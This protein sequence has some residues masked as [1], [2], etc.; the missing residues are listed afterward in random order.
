MKKILIVED[1][2]LL[3]MDLE[4]A[5]SEGGY[6]VVADVVSGSEAIEAA[7][8]LLPDLILM[9][10]HLDGKMDGI[11]AAGIIRKELHLPVIYLTAHSDDA[12]LERAQDTLPYGYIVKPFN[13]RELYSMIKMALFKHKSERH[14]EEEKN[15]LELANATLLSKAKESHIEEDTLFSL[16]S[17]YIYDQHESQLLFDQE[18]IKLT[19]KEKAF[20]DVM[21]KNIGHTVSFENIEQAVWKDEIPAEG[22]LRS[23]VRRVRDKL[24]EPL[25]ENITGC[26]YKLIDRR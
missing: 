9:D 24:K 2:A 15:E 10:I 21:V 16:G 3:A 17:H 1:D 5:L 12:T 22:T 6:D 4:S 18:P 20:F 23:L 8:T 7:Q 19:K 26:G 11:M 13:E 14:I 25:I